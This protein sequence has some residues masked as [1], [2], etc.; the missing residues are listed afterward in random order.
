LQYY[1]HD[2]RGIHAAKDLEDD[3]TIVLIPYRFIMTTEVAKASPIGRAIIQSSCLIRSKHSYLAAYLLG[4]REKGDSSF[5]HPYITVLPRDYRNMPINF[6]ED[7]KSW[8]SGSFSLTKMRQRI[9]SL[10]E[11]YDDICAHVPDFR[12]FTFH[13]FSWARHVVITRIFGL[14]IGGLKTE[15][16]V[17]LADLLNHK[18]PRE[19]KWTFE[20][21][22]NAFT[23]ITMRSH[24]KG[25]Q[26]FDSYGRKCNHRFFVNYG[27][28]L[29]ENEDNECV[30]EFSIHPD[31]INYARKLRLVNN[32][33]FHADTSGSGPSREFQIPANVR[34]RKTREMLS[35]LRFV[36][37]DD[38]EL[39][40]M[41]TSYSFMIDDISPVNVRNE[42]AALQELRKGALK[43]LAGF[44]GSIDR[45]NALLAT[46]TL[47]MNLRNA[48]LMRRG[49][50]MVANFFVH[51]ADACEP[52]L[53]MPWD[54]FHQAAEK[55]K[56]DEDVY[57]Y[58]MD[59]VRP[60]VRL[61]R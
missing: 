15:G 20:N 33:V 10:Q 56:S 58:V 25:E 24:K 55:L 52:L 30:L 49:E 34:E 11:E 12:R 41:P 54:E 32:A 35:F 19:T 14:V 44:D 16:L 61:V 42:I 60:L 22:K 23:I 51:L 31:D 39:G 21:A 36:V 57:A 1:A 53:K 46:G 5:W 4:E 48:V 37:A 3:E 26:V 2:Y 17:P 13:D 27:F 28:S 45:D 38:V 6:D 43:C 40:R 29:E 9:E 47:T 8:L 50:K 7:E 18:R 59:V